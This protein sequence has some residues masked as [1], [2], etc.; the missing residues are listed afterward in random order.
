MRRLESSR[1]GNTSSA[2]VADSMRGNA[3]KHGERH[4]AADLR[5]LRPGLFVLPQ[6]KDRGIGTHRLRVRKPLFGQDICVSADDFAK[7]HDG[8][9][10][11]WNET[12]AALPDLTR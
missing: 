4:S 8:S 12:A 6:F 5:Q 3:V 10:A 11:F 7:Y 1:K 9:A 2:A